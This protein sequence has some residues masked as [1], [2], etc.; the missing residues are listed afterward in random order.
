MITDAP[1]S[2][3]ASAAQHA[4]LPAPTTITSGFPKSVLLITFLSDA[5]MWTWPVR[6]TNRELR[7][8]I[9]MQCLGWRRPPWL[10]LGWHRRRRRRGVVRDHAPPALGAQVHVGR[11]YRPARPRLPGDGYVLVDAVHREHHALHVLLVAQLETHRL[12]A[13]ENLAP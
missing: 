1:F 4:A 3:A 8:A 5:R 7:A 11:H 9:L 2:R 10:G 6:A 13:G 12:P